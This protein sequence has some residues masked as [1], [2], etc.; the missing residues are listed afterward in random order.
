MIED[1]PGRDVREVWRFVRGDTNPK[2]FE[3]WVCADAALEERFGSALYLDLISAN[4]SDDQIVHELKER[5]GAWALALGGSECRCIRLADLAVVDMGGDDA[6]VFST[7][8]DEVAR[9]DPFWWLSARICSACGD[10]WLVAQEERQ[11]DVFCMRR[12]SSD[13]WRR[14]QSRQGWPSDFDRYEDADVF[15]G[16]H[17]LCFHLEF[18]HGETDPD[19]PCSDFSSCPWWTIRHYEA[20]LRELGVDPAVVIEQAIGQQVH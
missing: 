16:M 12:L 8:K 10:Q 5:L 14:I 17:W 7:L 3:R 13:E 6:V 18:E 2:A 11:N 4:Y 20:K 1:W 15:E 9:G 19:L